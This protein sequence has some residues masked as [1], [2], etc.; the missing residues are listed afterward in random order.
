MHQ[1]AR[2]GTRGRAYKDIMIVKVILTHNS[3]IREKRGGVHRI[4]GV[5]KS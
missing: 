2:E 4:A 5:K 3:S 1:K